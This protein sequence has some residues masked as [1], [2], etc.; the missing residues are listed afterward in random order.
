M[1]DT[2]EI[3]S[4]ASNLG[5]LLASHSIV[6]GYK[7]TLRQLDLD[8]A[9]RNLLQQYE[10]LVET[11]SAKEAQMQPI[12]VAEKHQFEQL[13]QAIMMSPTLKKFATAQGE[14]MDLMRKVPGIDQQRHRR[15]SGARGRTRRRPARRAQQDHPGYVIPARS[16]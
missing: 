15:E 4:A 3:L 12:E 2:P 7:E 5:A 6:S 8:V 1:A 13:Q 16:E 14:Y 11:L 9:A 10:Q